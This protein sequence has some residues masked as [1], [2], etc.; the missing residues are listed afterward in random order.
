MGNSHATFALVGAPNCGKTT[1]FNVLTGAHQAVGNW[2]GVT[3]ER[4]EGRL[5]LPEKTVRLIDLPGLYSLLAEDDGLDQKVSREFLLEESIE[6]I[7]HVVDATQLQRQLL[8]CAQLQTFNLPIIVVVNMLDVAEQENLTIDLQRLAENMDLCVVGLC[9]A[10]KTGV[11]ELKRILSGPQ[12]ASVINEDVPADPLDVVHF[13]LQGVVSAPSNPVTSLSERIDQWVLHRVFG[14]PVFL[15]MMYLMFNIAINLGAVFIDAFDMMAGTFFIDT[16]R[17]GLQAVAAPGWLTLVIADGLGGGIQVVAT[18]IP[19]IACL[20]LTLSL[21]ESSGYMARAAFVV[22]R[23]MAAIGLPGKAFVPLIV[24]FG[25]NVPA[26]MAARTLS[27]PRDRMV[28]V[29]MAPFMSCGAR[30]AVYT[31]FVAAIFHEQGQNIVF[32]LYLI[33]IIMAVL[34]GWMFRRF[35]PETDDTISVMEMPAYHLPRWR[36]ILMQT[37][38][39]LSGFIKR[40]GRTIVVMYALLTVVSAY[41]PEQ[42][43]GQKSAETLMETAGQSM[44]LLFEPMG[45]Q[46]DNWPAMVGILAGV[47][48]KEAV[49]GTLDA[50]YSEPVSRIAVRTSVAPDIRAKSASALESIG[51]NLIALG[52]GM[53]APLG[54]QTP[55]VGLA[56]RTEASIGVTQ[57]SLNQIEARFGSSLAAF[58]YLIFILLYTPCLAMISTLVREAGTFWSLVVCSWSTVLAYCVGTSCYQLGSFADHPWQS[59]IW[60]GLMGGLLWSTRWILFYLTRRDQAK[61]GQRIELLQVS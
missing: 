24:G 2:P 33:G 36:N 17:Y 44:T 40:A 45:I 52:E 54:I 1:L 3:V 39:R 49:V 48:A 16:V 35:F 23:L 19:V 32:A 22:D 60:L 59:L 56:S 13:W 42:D 10:D 57:N 58:S 15:L 26:V 6:A 14:I 61:Q 43:V 28:T 34:S 51:D 11:P 55:N 25:C 38:H 41:Q 7:I 27:N 30:L 18:F 12:K 8:L 20:Y 5:Q 53:L 50:L 37:R 9:A 21:L 31:L 47:F 4:K 46:R 29:A